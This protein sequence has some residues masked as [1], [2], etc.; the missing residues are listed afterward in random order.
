MAR[1]FFNRQE[2]AAIAANAGWKCEICAQPLADGW[3]ADH[4]IPYSKGGAT[5]V[6]NGQALCPPCNMKKG[7]NTIMTHLR[8]WQQEAINRFVL[9]DSQNFLVTACPGAGKTTYALTA[10]RE[11]LDAGEVSRVVVVVPSDALRTQWADNTSAGVDLRPL[12]GADRIDHPD[13][14]G[15]V[16]TYQ[17]L[18]GSVAHMIRGAIGDGDP[19][20]TLV[21]L[22]EIHHAADSSSYGRSLEYAFEH[23]RSRLLLTGTPW[24]TD[25]RERMPFVEFDKNN[26]LKVDYSYPYGRA[27]RDGVCRPIDFPVVDGMASWVR[28][29]EEKSEQLTVNRSLKGRD[30][31]DAMRT[32][33]DPASKGEWMR[34]VIERAHADLM[35]I[36]TEC[37]RA[38]GLIVAK[39]KI[40]AK[41]IQELLRHVTGVNAPVVVSAEDEGGSNKD[42][43]K[44]IERFRTSSEPW[45][46]AVKMIA[47]GVDIPRLTV[48][49]YATNVTTAMFFTQVIGRFVRVNKDVQAVSR[50]YIPPSAALWAAAQEIQESLPQ[51]L[52]LEEA[53]PRDIRDGNGGSGHGDFTVLSSESSGL[54]QVLTLNGTVD[55]GLVSEWESFFAGCGVPIHFSANAAAS[56]GLPP[57]PNK[58]VDELP[59]HRQQDEKRAAIN[60][61]VG[62]VAYKCYGNF[63]DKRQV[64][65]DLNG[66]F[67]VCSVE[68]MSI[69]QLTA[70]QA[71]LESR[72]SE[73]ER[74]A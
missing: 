13:Y 40:H 18:T 64:W 72:L 42:A 16:T 31:S 49:V 45:I 57:T 63:R 52:S 2:K 61:L 29:Q 53:A 39:N 55:G 3:H 23:A 7:S 33:L 73:G 50:L 15:V 60:T 65:F 43:R 47:E 70:A 54:A 44:Q 68:D 32:I 21:V 46:I 4:R 59:K 9:S 10:A 22:D 71:L 1:R 58:P 74:I 20:G 35:S 41:Q 26:M 48:G 11:L 51:R 56:G 66:Y 14:H 5:D 67:G 38:G 6:V 28:D 12:V 19:R 27:V 25:E 8:N 37:P 36:R 17:A 30:L 24:R 62:R 34:A 69:D